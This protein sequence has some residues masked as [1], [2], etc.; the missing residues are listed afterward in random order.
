[1]IFS[2]L[3][4]M[5]IVNSDNNIYF[6]HEFYMDISQKEKIRLILLEDI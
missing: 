5:I 2:L 1:M 3:E 4:M 6:S